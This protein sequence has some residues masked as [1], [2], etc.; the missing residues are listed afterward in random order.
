MMAAQFFNARHYAG[1]PTLCVL[2][3]CNGDSAPAMPLFGA[4]FPAWLIAALIGV[5]A[6]IAARIALAFSGLDKVVPWLLAVCSSIGLI[7]AIAVSAVIFG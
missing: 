7:I 3:G 4:Y 6:A 1:L 5:I 2:A